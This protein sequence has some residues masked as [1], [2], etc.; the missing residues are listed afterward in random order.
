MQITVSYL[1]Y[2]ILAASLM[3][4]CSACQ[5]I[6]V[7]VCFYVCVYRCVSL[8]FIISHTILDFG[9][10]KANDDSC[11]LMLLLLPLSLCILLLYFSLSFFTCLYNTIKYRNIALYNYC[12]NV[13]ILI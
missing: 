3:Y 8:R 10:I 12:T 11:S 13:L 7:F 2:L 1:L 4:T 5:C 9:G 6:C